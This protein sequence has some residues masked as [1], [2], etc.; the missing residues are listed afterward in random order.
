MRPVVSVQCSAGASRSVAVGHLCPGQSVRFTGCA[1]G[2]CQADLVVPAPPGTG[3]TGR[4]T[5]HPDHWRLDNPGPVPL[6]VENLE[7]PPGL[8]TVPAGRA[9]VVI[10]FELA[11]VS[12]S[13]G[14]TPLVT[15]FGPEPAGV[16]AP[17]P[18]CPYAAGGVGPDRQLDPAATYF[19]VLVALCEPRLRESVDAVLPTSAEI[20]QRLAQRGITVS[21]RAVD[22]HIEYLTEKLDLRAS[23]QIGRP[24]R[25]WRKEA[26]AAAALRRLLVRPEH[27]PYA[28][29]P[30]RAGRRTPTRAN[31]QSPP[32]PPG[33]VDRVPGHL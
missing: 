3:G 30:T 10:P 18:A 31:G 27:V 21:P 17:A 28:A 14:R 26:V 2:G 19:A 23:G 11:R 13:S 12:A 4:V 24:R 6:V 32:R 29:P 15:V 9:G 20:A 8:V 7:Q 25:G 16:A 5:A 22:W 1:C 33:V